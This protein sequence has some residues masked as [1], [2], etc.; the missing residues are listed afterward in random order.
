MTVEAVTFDLDGTLL[1]TIDDIADAVNSALRAFDFP[2]RTIDDYKI[3]VGDGLMTLAKRV[4]P[5]SAPEDILD[6]FVQAVLGQYKEYWDKKTHP[7]DGIPELLDELTRR[8]IPMSV[9]SNKPHEFTIL[10]I[11]R[12]LKKWK[13]ASIL[14]ARPGVDKKPSPI[15][16]MQIAA[17]LGIAPEKI[18][19]VGDTATDVETGHNAGNTTVGVTWGF[20]ERAELEK[21]GAHVIID[22]PSEFFRFLDD[23]R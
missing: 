11:A 22:H 17:Q 5:E 12:F 2:E 7:Y 14:G 19:H 18:V 3:F 9:L 13:F 4:L 10:T 23:E 16:S 20:R 8:G 15:A 6:P 1:N 21:A